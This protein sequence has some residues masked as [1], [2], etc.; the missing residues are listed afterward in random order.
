MVSRASAFVPLVAALARDAVA[1][2]LVD[3][4]EASSS[5][6]T[7]EDIELATAEISSRTAGIGVACTINEHMQRMI[8]S[9]RASGMT[10]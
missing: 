2:G 5:P 10:K 3:V 8:E 6:N 4:R 7:D 9:S 1:L